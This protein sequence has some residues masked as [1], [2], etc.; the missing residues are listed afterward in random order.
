M[1]HFNR[2]RNLI[3]DH[4]LEERQWLEECVK[5]L[6][7]YKVLFVSVN[8]SL[9]E[10]QRRERERGDRNMGLANYQYNLVHSHGV[11]DLEVDT[12][13]NNTHECALQIKKCLHENSHFSAFTELKQRA[14]NRTKVYE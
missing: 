5:L 6:A 4:V 13:V 7:D 8:C 12:E 1:R 11:Y 3:V 2:L 14:G 9:E 10:L